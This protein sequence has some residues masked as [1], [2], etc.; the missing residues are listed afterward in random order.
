M[1]RIWTIFVNQ[2]L[3]LI[4]KLLIKVCDTLLSIEALKMLYTVIFKLT[5]IEKLLIEIV[6][7]L[8]HN[9]LEYSQ[10]FINNKNLQRVSFGNL[11]FRFII[12][13]LYDFF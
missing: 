8:Q 13:I 3:I 6:C 2:K 5:N 9:R 11:Y 4:S 12:F 7:K 10:Y 1:L